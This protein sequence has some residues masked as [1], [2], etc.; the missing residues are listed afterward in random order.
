MLLWSPGLSLRFCGCLGLA[1]SLGLDKP[2]GRGKLGS[3]V[4]QTPEKSGLPSASRGEGAD[5]STLPSAFRGTPARTPAAEEG[6]GLGLAIARG[7]VE[8]HGGSIDARNVTDGC[9]F[10][11]RFRA[12]AAGAV[13]PITGRSAQIETAS[14]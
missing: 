11:V 12:E 4:I 2:P 13:S 14:T 6:A 10:T 5:I 9:R 1:A 7:I 3:P 8:A